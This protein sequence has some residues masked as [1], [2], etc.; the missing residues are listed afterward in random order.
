MGLCSWYTCWNGSSDM[1]RMCLSFGFTFRLGLLKLRIIYFKRHHLG[2][3]PPLVPRRICFNPPSSKWVPRYS[4]NHYDIQCHLHVHPHTP[5]EPS[6]MGSVSYPRFLGVHSNHFRLQST[7]T[8]TRLGMGFRFLRSGHLCELLGIQS[9]IQD[10]HGGIQEIT[11]RIGFLAGDRILDRGGKCTGLWKV[12]DKSIG[13]RCVRSS[14]CHYFDYHP[15]VCGHRRRNSGI[16]VTQSRI[17]AVLY[18]Q[19]SHAPFTFL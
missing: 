6:D 9:R 8:T 4:P 3:L 2:I 12:T 14:G 1:G 11:I 19:V 7:L 10:Y 13:V 18:R 16:D 15:G 5:H 17:T